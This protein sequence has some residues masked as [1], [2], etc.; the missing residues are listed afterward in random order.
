MTNTRS[1]QPTGFEHLVHC[2]APE[3][4]RN[5]GHWFVFRGDQLLVETSDLPHGVPAPGSEMKL[6]WAVADTLI[7]PAS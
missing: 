4:A 1:A 7:Y 2:E 5:A 6:G 3:A